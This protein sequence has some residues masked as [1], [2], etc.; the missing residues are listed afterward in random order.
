M[1]SPENFTLLL[2]PD[3]E[4]KSVGNGSF[5]QVFLAI[6]NI[7]KKIYAIKHMD[8][9]KLIHYLNCLIRYMQKLIYNPE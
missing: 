8:K 7:D 1:F 4:P 6:N 9:E 3:G 5:G 2:I